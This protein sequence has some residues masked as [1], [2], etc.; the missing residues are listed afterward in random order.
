MGE[1][2][3]VPLFCQLGDVVPCE[4]QVDVAVHV[5]PARINF[6]V[7]KLQATVNVVNGLVNSYEM[8]LSFPC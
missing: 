7:G 5:A 2:V 6:R 1:E 8:A 3:G 4:W